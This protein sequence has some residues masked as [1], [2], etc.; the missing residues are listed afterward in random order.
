MIEIIPAIDIY[1]GKCVRLTRGD[2]HQ[3]TVYHERPVDL[4]RQFEE[5]GI[6]RIHLVDLEGASI[7]K[8]ANIEILRSITQ[9]TELHVDFGGGISSE[10]DLETVFNAGA[11]Q[12]V[13]GSL[14][15]KQPELFSQWLERFGN[16][17]FILGADALNGK[18]AVSGWSEL[19]DRSLEDFLQEYFEKGIRYVMSTDISRDGMMQGSSVELYKVLKEKFPS[20]NIIASGGITSISEI[21]ELEASGLYGVI[22]GKAL[23]EKKIL[24]NELTRFIS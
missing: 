8:I 21:E 11:K 20:L 23:Y 1:Q 15:V 22:I 18:I 16:E 7:R 3:M 14:A 4:A 6:K 5:H 10:S 17:N 12:A 13:I 2:Y 24:I 9:A 19:S